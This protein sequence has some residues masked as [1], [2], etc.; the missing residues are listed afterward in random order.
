MLCGHFIVLILTYLHL[1][2][3]IVTVH[4]ILNIKYWVSGADVLLRSLPGACA[5]VEVSMLARGR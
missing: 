1:K 2:S 3:L 4:M 5:L